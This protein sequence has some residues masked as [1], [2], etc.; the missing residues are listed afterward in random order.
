MGRSEFF[1]LCVTV[2]IRTITIIL[3]CEFLNP[4]LKKKSL[5]FLSV[6]FLL[7]NKKAKFQR[8]T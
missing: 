6:D 2:K 3:V 8:L 1:C 5:D 4:E 7:I